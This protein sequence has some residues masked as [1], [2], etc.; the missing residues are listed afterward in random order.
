MVYDI[1]KRHSHA[2]ASPPPTHRRWLG[3]F[4]TAEEA[5]VV[6]DIRKREIKGGAAKCNFPALDMSGPTGA[7]F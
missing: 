2:S 3:T 1:R 6:Y 5:A 4:D 7:P